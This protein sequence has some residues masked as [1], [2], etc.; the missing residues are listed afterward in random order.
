[1]KKLF[2]ALTFC[3]SAVAFAQAGQATSGG[4][5]GTMEQ[6]GLFKERDAFDIQGT[7]QK[8]DDDDLTLAREGLPAV[9]LDVHPRTVVTLD[10]NPS[11]VEQLPQGAQ[12]RAKFQLRDDDIIAVRIEATSGSGGSGSAGS[13][14]EQGAQEAGQEVQDT[15]KDVKDEVDQRLNE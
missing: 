8:V 13:K 12:V 11:R 15:A 1:M 10:G 7:V 6:Q 2:A 14:L 5:S 3:V 4:R 9:E